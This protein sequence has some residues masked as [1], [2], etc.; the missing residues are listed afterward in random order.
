MS[1]PN[2]TFTETIL[3]KRPP[4]ATPRM[5]FSPDGNRVG[6][7]AR[8]DAGA[9]IEINGVPVFTAEK[10]ERIFFTPD[11]NHWIALTRCGAKW[12]VVFDGRA[13]SEFD[14]VQNFVFSPGDD[15]LAFVGIRG[16]RQV[17]VI[18]GVESPEHDSVFGLTWGG[19]GRVL[20]AA[21]DGGSAQLVIDG[22]PAGQTYKTMSPPVVS[23][24]GKSIAT[25][26][27][28]PDGRE[29]VVVNGTEGGDHE[30]VVAVVMTLDG[31]HVAYAGY[32]D[33][34]RVYVDET[35]GAAYSGI[36]PI[37]FSPG[38]ARMAYVVFAE[39]DE[40][41]VVVDGAAELGHRR[42][43]EVQFSPDGNRLLYVAAD[44]S[45]SV[46][47]VDSVEHGPFDAVTRNVLFS[48]E[49][50]RWTAVVKAGSQ[51]V[52]VVDGVS[53]QA[54]DAV[55]QPLLS[56]DGAVVAY[57]AERSGSRLLVINETEFDEYTGELR[58]GGPPQLV[59]D[60]QLMFHI[61]R[62]EEVV[63]VDAAIAV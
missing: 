10:V 37:V 55:E 21:Y 58:V 30:K 6:W 4:L 59:N 15:R 46:V 14:R 44:V 9:R 17:A 48:A 25:A 20:F 27:R 19:D 26:V 13:S 50:T 32:D 3:A 33:L 53:G 49:S 51:Q 18:D 42:V 29:L 28:R 61:L 35:P 8:D 40:M 45:R 39:E 7:A 24:N 34:A 52:V 47:V 36:G 5:G 12:V 16:T 56:A 11:S 2:V 22:A 63:R 57:S 31:K 54:Y 60:R 23:R 62:D 1:V 43:D 38:G 41:F